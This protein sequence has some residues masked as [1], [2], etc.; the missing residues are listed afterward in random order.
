MSTHKIDFN[1][2]LTKIIFQ[3]LSNTH[4]ISSSVCMNL[5]L[6]SNM[7]SIILFHSAVLQ[8]ISL[9]YEW[10]ALFQP[11]ETEI[12]RDVSTDVAVSPIY[13]FLVLLFLPRRPGCH[14]WGNK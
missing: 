6:Y 13:Q 7:M 8:H 1:E 14:L 9:V 11:A 5:L 3:L 12:T 4:L 2:D 10:R